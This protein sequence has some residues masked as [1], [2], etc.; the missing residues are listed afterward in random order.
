MLRCV[1][2]YKLTDVS[3]TFTASIIMAITYALMM[4][5]V[6]TTDRRSNST[7]LHGAISQKTG[8]FILAAVTT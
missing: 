6:S 5:T 8:I 7:G 3:E 4:E 1:A 2:W